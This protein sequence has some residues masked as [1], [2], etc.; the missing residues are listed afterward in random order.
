MYQRLFLYMTIA[1]L[2]AIASETSQSILPIGYAIALKATLQAL[3]AWRAYIDLTPANCK[4]VN[5]L[6]VE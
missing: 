6:R 2:T 3:I 4:E 1:V 5:S